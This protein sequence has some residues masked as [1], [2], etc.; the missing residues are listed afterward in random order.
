MK[1][2]NDTIFGNATVYWAA[3]PV[4]YFMDGPVVGGSGILDVARQTKERMKAFGYAWRMSKDT[5]WVDRAY[6][7]M[8]V[9]PP[10]SFAVIHF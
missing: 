4:P 1:A 10:V 9:C 8:Q 3:D 5:K 2:W 6:R 7:E